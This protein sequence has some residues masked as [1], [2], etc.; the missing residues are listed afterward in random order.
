MGLLGLARRWCWSNRRR[1]RQIISSSL[2][3]SDDFETTFLF[4]R[5]HRWPYQCISCHSFTT[6]VS[7]T[8][9]CISCIG[10]LQEPAS[11]DNYTSKLPHASALLH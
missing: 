8:G 2:F 11:W 9:Y 10:H 3:D 5:P 7:C 1:S 6:S 4:L